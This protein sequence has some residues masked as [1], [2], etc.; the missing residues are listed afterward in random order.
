[1][2]RLRVGQ[3]VEFRT[4]ERLQEL[5]GDPEGSRSGA[6]FVPDMSYLSGQRVRIIEILGH[7][8]DGNYVWIESLDGSDIPGWSYSEDM[9]EAVEEV[10]QVHRNRPGKEIRVGDYVRIK[11]WKEIQKSGNPDI[12]GGISPPN[13]LWRFVSRM[14]PLCNMEGFVEEVSELGR[15]VIDNPIIKRS[16]WSIE[17]WMLKKVR[18]PQ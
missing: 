18:A 9:F 3:V 14:K 6:R 16:D 17:G 7:E 13:S 11:S 10:Q 4:R 15:V 5:Y 12:D 8:P 2:P 1:M